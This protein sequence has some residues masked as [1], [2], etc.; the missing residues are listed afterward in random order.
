MKKKSYR[1]ST[2]EKQGGALATS[3]LKHLKNEALPFVYISTGT[4]T[5]F[6]DYTDSKARSERYSVSIDQKH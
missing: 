5:R 4:I 2:H 3:K 1:T 6:T